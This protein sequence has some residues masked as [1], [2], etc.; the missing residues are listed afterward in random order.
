MIRKSA[1]RKVIIVFVSLVWVL[2]WLSVMGR[3]QPLQ[4]AQPTET[5]APVSQEVLLVQFQADLAPQERLAAIAQLGGELL[6]WLPALQTAQIRLRPD[7]SPWRASTQWQELVANQVIVAAEPDGLVQAAMAPNDPA[8]TDQRK[9]YA[10]ELLNLPAAWDYTTGGPEILI[11]ILDSGITATHPEFSGQLQPGYDFVQQDQD[12][13]DENGHGTHVAGIVGAQINNQI[14]VAGLCAHCQLLPVRVLNAQNIGSW[15]NVAQGVTYAVDQG[16]RVIVMSLGSSVYSHTMKN[17]VDYAHARG[18]ILVAAAGNANAPD[19]FYPAAFPEVMGVGATTRQ[20]QRWSF[21]N[22]GQNVD[23]MA[24]G[25][26]IYSTYPAWHKDS[27]EYQTLTGTS[28]AA[29]FVA[30]L[31]GL[32]LAQNPTRSITEVTQLITTTAID[33]GEPGVDSRFGAGRIDVGAAFAAGAPTPRPASRLTGA[34]WQDLDL[35]GQFDPATEQALSNVVIQVQN[36]AGQP[37][38]LA[39]TGATGA[40][41]M[42]GLPTGAYTMQITSTLLADLTPPP[43]L[44]VELTAPVTLANLN[45]GFVTQPTPRAITDFTVVRTTQNVTLTWTVVHPLVDSI[46]VQR[47]LTETGEYTTVFTRTI[48]PQE[49]AAK[50]PIRL[51][52]YLPAELGQVNVYYRL[53]LGPNNAILGPKAVEPVH[54][55]WAHTLYLPLLIRNPEFAQ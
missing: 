8:I 43:A 19:P 41:Q 10:P 44:R 15:M 18:V 6:T 21:S 16:A 22:Y 53:L 52:D 33:L 24:P 32:L 54:G 34:A 46:R 35:N 9:V 14:G 4:A 2:S 26:N 37:M 30:G 49:I 17:A 25:D 40:W 29:P 45:F 55:A 23:V 50:Q 28:M 31:A 13:T 1:T 47:A 11:A 5:L 39:V 38:G 20:D 48:M 27:P 7:R 51:L 36:E 42:S 3:S 12:P